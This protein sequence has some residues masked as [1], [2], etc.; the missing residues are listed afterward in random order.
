MVK[1]D[2][3]GLT[4]QVSSE[5]PTN[6]TGAITAQRLR[7]YLTDINDSLGNVSAA[8]DGRYLRGTAVDG[9]LTNASITEDVNEILVEKTA[10]FT[11]SINIGSSQVRVLG[12]LVYL[13]TTI[14]GRAF[15]PMGAPFTTAGTS[16]PMYVK[17]GASEELPETA[18]QRT[19]DETLALTA[20]QSM[21][22]TQ[23]GGAGTDHI[24]RQFVVSAT[25]AGTLRLEIFV[26]TDAT[27]RKIVDQQYSVIIGE[28]TLAF[29]SFPYINPSY[30]YFIRYTAVTDVTIRGTTISTV[31]TPYSVVS[32]WPFSEVRV[33]TDDDGAHVA[34][35]IEALTGDDRLDYTTLRNLPATGAAMLT[36]T[37]IAVDGNVTAGVWEPPSFDANH[38]ILDSAQVTGDITSVNASSGTVFGNDTFFAI[39]NID[40]SDRSFTLND[41]AVNFSGL[42]GGAQSISLP[43][44][45]TTL[46]FSDLGFPA[47]IANYSIG[48]ASGQHPL[49]VQRDTP[50]QTTLAAI[51]SAS[52]GGNSGLWVV[53]NDQISANEANVPAAVQI[54]ALRAGILNANNVEIS[55]TATAK[56]G[57]VLA[58]GSIVRIFSDTDLRVVSSPRAAQGAR[59]PD[60]PIS[61]TIHINQAALY[62]IYRNRTL[63][64]SGSG[65]I[66]VRL[67]SLQNTGEIAFTNYD[68]VFCFRNDGTGTLR[69]RT[70][71]VNTVFSSNQSDRIDI[72]PGILVCVRPVRWSGS[73]VAVFNVIQQ[74]Q[75]SDIMIEDIAINTDWYRDDT[76]A[77]A[78]DNYVRLHNRKETTDGLVKDH[79]LTSSATNNPISLRFQRIDFQDDIAWIQWWS[80]FDTNVPPLTSGGDSPGAIIASI[81]AALSYIQTNINNGFD[82]VFR[83]FEGTVAIQSIDF[84]SGNTV[85]LVLEANVPDLVSVNH[86]IEVQSATNAVHNGTWVVDSI[87]N[88]T[89]IHITNPGVSD[90]TADEATTPAF[91]DVPVYCD[92][93]LVSHDLRQVNFN[94]YEDDARTSLLA[95]GDINANWFDHTFDGTGSVLGIGYNT[96]VSVTTSQVAIQDAKEQF[97]LAM[98]GGR[99]SVHLLFNGDPN[100]GGPSVPEY[101]ATRPIPENHPVIH[102]QTQG[103]ADFYFNTESVNIPVGESRQYRIYSDPDNDS[104]DVDI[105][106]GHSTASHFFQFFDNTVPVFPLSNGT[107]V[108]IEGYND[109]TLH[110]WRITSAFEKVVPS[111]NIYD[112]AVTAFTGNIPISVVTQVLLTLS[113][114]PSYTFVTSSNQKIQL[115]TGLEARI[116]AQIDVLFNGTEGTGLLFAPITLMPSFER[117]A[118]TTNLPQF[119]D[120]TSLLLSRNGQSGAAAPK[121]GQTLKVDFIY[122]PNASDLIG[123]EVQFGTLPAGYSATDFQF[124]NFR[125]TVTIQG[126]LD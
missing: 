94:M 91:I 96:D 31:F 75:A 43:A 122:Q 93:V 19:Q 24:A 92:A 98:G 76:D 40:S 30:T 23:V 53:A 105:R 62:S 104:N 11:P 113:E 89:T 13:Q 126:N 119:A 22:F 79:I 14:S 107:F 110:G 42:G 36:S 100:D 59:Y 67:F 38:L 106:V 71:Q 85:R 50:S 18:Q 26:G 120:R 17:L 101:L 51:A 10:A 90:G 41:V 103:T 97:H 68:D 52:T 84:V 34:D 57:V 15:S 2:K 60:I 3:A 124:Q 115:S 6:T 1:R 46:F 88:A 114:D 20:G 35:L 32:G 77:T 111:I 5:F 7:D 47:P 102:I 123:F 78:A 63:V 37:N 44:R 69:L 99:R 117:A 9:V 16:N 82:F 29:D 80:T 112:T 116:E 39:S 27:G 108:D 55:T 21:A 4:S 65:T 12:E 72:G 25:Q 121:F 8:E 49:T 86:E 70:F 28:T 125:Y 61:S 66:E 83:P 73:G 54:R 109:G 58:A 118:V 74:G 56:S 48:A 64:Y 87:P 45:T 81:P 33:L 95:A